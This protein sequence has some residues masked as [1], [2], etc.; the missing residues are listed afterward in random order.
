MSAEIKS[1]FT[2]NSREAITLNFLVIFMMTN[3]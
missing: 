2:K 1:Y 3:K